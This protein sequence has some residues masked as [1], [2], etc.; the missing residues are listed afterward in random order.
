MSRLIPTQISALK[1]AKRL[2]SILT[3][4]SISLAVFTVNAAQTTNQTTATV[5]SILQDIKHAEKKLAKTQTHIAKE[6]TVLSKKIFDKEQAL[7]KLRKEAAINRRLADEDTLSLNK[8][9]T[10]LATWQQQQQ[11][12]LNLLNRFVREHSNKDQPLNTQA[13][14]LN[15]VVKVIEVQEKSLYP[16]FNSQTIVLNNGDLTQASTLQVGPVTWFYAKAPAIAGLLDSTEQAEIAKVALIQTD[17]ADNPLTLAMQ[18]LQSGTAN[19]IKAE[20]TFDPSLTRMIASQAQEENAFEHMKKGGLWVLPIMAFACFALVIA[21]LKAI[22]LF[23]LAKIKQHSQAQ[24]VQLFSQQKLDNFSG[25][26][27][28]LFQLSLDNS[29]GTARDDQLF[30][31]LTHNKHQLENWVGAIAI[32]ASVS[33]LLGLLGTVSGMI[34]TFKMMTLFGSGD[35]EVVSGG[36]AQALITTELGLV[37]AIPALVLNALLSRK[38]KSYYTQLEAFAVQLSQLE[39]NNV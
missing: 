36:I 39:K 18:S 32:T 34:E 14:L 31:Q 15:D 30:N 21:L 23:R 35:P 20:L 8:L 38:V 37:V 22:Q 11:Y 7:S 24:L 1:S 25:M 3:I 27:R 19:N 16:Q 29:K 4:L 33:P 17:S 12:Q 28:S 9:Q 13:S 6:Q 26:Q 5:N 10:R 2:F